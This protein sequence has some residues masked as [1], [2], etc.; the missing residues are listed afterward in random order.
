MS[1]PGR[2]LKLCLS[3]DP[4]SFAAQAIG[5][6]IGVLDALCVCLCE[7]TSRPKFS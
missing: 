5:Q 4:I 1:I 6:D 7:R 3:A 2:R